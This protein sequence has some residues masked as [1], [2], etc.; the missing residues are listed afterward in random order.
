MEI[1][2][3]RLKTARLL[4]QWTQSQLAA[5]AGVSTGTVGNIESG[6]RLAP[7]SLPALAEALKIN[8]K[9]LAHGTGDMLD[10]P[11]TTPETGLT[12][13]ALELA[14]LYDMIPT[15]QRIKR[16]QAYTAAAQAIVAVLEGHASAL[17]TPDKKTP[18]S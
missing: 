14:R 11:S 2:S 15:A 12:A 7:G 1:L 6:I 5:A 13:G 3:S 16:A 17:P 8:Y 18:A 10:N 4:R 9:W